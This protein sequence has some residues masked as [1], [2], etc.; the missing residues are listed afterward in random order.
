MPPFLFLQDLSGPH[1]LV[2]SF[3]THP[4]SGHVSPSDIITLLQTSIISHVAM[5]PASS[6][7]CLLAVHKHP[8]HL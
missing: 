4:E 6:L 2:T 5:T 7:V 8:H 3:K 1:V